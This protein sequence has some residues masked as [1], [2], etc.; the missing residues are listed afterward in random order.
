M[1]M[2]CSN[3]GCIFVAQSL[4]SCDRAAYDPEKS[5]IITWL[6]GYLKWRLQDYRTQMQVAQIQIAARQR[7]NSNETTDPLENLA[8]P[9][10]VPPIAETTFSCLGNAIAL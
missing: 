1:K 10:D 8:A 7:L 5:S 2:R 3:S 4:Q 6:N 9:P